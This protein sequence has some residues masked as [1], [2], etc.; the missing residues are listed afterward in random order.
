MKVTP[1]NRFN[2]HLGFTYA[3]VGNPVYVDEAA[4]NAYTDDFF[5]TYPDVERNAIND[6]MQIGNEWGVTYGW[7]Y[8]MGAVGIRSNH[9]LMKMSGKSYT[10]ELYYMVPISRIFKAYLN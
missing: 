9:K 10:F 2:F 3:T 5:A 4:A 6:P 1:M 8:E 7:S